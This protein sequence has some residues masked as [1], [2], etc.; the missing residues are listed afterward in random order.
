MNPN[1][2][3]SDEYVT[4]QRKILMRKNTG[5]DRTDISTV[6]SRCIWLRIRPTGELL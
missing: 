3:V 1:G 5:E 4:Q 2:Y 6:L